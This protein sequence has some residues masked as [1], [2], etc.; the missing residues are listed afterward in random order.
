MG[1]GQSVVVLNRDDWVMVDNRVLQVVDVH[2]GHVFL[3][4]DWGFWFEKELVK[5]DPSLNKILSDSIS[6]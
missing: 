6:N 5:V 3:R 1:N 4:G 2:N